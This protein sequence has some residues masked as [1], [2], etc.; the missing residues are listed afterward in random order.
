MPSLEEMP[1]IVMKNILEFAGFQAIMTLRKVSHG[2]RNFIDDTLPEVYFDVIHITMDPGKVIFHWM[3]N[4]IIV[5]IKYQKDDNGCMV[6]NEEKK[7]LL[8]NMDYLT[9]CL[10]DF[11]RTLKHQKSI[12]EGFHLYL[13]KRVD[14][15]TSQTFSKTLKNIFQN[16]Q[17]KVE[18]VDLGVMNPRDFLSILPFVSSKTL[19]DINLFNTQYSTKYIC[20]DEFSKLDQWKNAE[21]IEIRNYWIVSKVEDF[22]HF[23]NINVDFKDL[24]AEDL[25][26]FKEVLL[27]NYICSNEKFHFRQPS[28]IRNLKDFKSDIFISMI[29]VE[30]LA[31][32]DH[33]HTFQ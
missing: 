4:S 6:I 33:L 13:D 20:L 5:I 10:E 26:V 32:W 31:S 14:H 11:E 2:L 16:H 3:I 22:S 7:K 29:L 9:V 19:K 28:K 30:S 25:V 27:I 15:Q 17:L 23:S 12:I 24:N 21:E 18:H 8:P 1:D